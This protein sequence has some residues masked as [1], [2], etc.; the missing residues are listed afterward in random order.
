MKNNSIVKGVAMGA[1]IATAVAVTA[2]AYFL[3][4]SKNANKNR[5]KV[6]SWTL[7]AK[8]EILEKLE[9]ISEVNEEIYQKIVE[10]VSKKYQALKNINE[11]DIAEFVKELKGH[12]KN[13]AK[14]LK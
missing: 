2:G 3:Y 4:G 5:K 14:E 12:W 6:K 11:K 8:G 13:I 10:G 9:N 7:K 1:G